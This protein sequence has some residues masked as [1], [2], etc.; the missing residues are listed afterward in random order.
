MTF[1]PEAGA[2]TLPSVERAW[3]AAPTPVLLRLRRAWETGVVSEAVFGRLLGGFVLL[4]VVAAADL[5]WRPP[6]RGNRLHARGAGAQPDRADV[7]LGR[8]RRPRARSRDGRRPR[9]PRPAG[10]L[11]RGARDGQDV[12]GRPPARPARR[13]L[14]R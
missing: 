5:A 4:V 3:I 14:A 8:L 7:D 1:H 12:G 11:R 13:A 6:W 2:A 9:K 10:G